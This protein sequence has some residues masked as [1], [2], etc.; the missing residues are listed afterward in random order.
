MDKISELQNEKKYLECRYINL[1][2]MNKK[3]KETISQDLSY[4]LHELNLANSSNDLNSIV[5][6]REQLPILI[7][8]INRAYSHLNALEG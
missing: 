1:L 7:G 2:Q 3:A 8:M 6:L 5:T 4:I